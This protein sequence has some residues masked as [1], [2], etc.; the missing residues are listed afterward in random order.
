MADKR[1]SARIIPRHDSASNWETKNPV[2]ENGE[3]ITVT[4]NAGAIRHKVGD[5]TKT[6]T[7]LPFED[8]P[9]YNALSGKC[10]ASV[11]VDAVLSASNWSNGQQ[12]VSV[13]G[14]KAT[15]NGFASLSQS[16]TDAQ[17][18]AAAAAEITVSNQS[19]GSLTFSYSGTA[20]QVDIPITIILLG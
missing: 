18:S 15:T 20:P 9:L 12:T 10:D 5:G 6:Y 17:Y 19:D 2:L 1:V 14:L 16:Y 3:L 13:D 4:T 8:E 7:Q 11:P